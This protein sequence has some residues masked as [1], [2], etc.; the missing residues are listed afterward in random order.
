MANVNDN[1]V[2]SASQ[3]NAILAYMQEGNTITTLEALNLFGCMRLASRINDLR[4][5]GY[6]IR[7]D[8]VVTPTGKRVAQYVLL[9]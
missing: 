2:Q 3:N 4:N 9:G 6:D 1:A 7:T 5:R 8:K